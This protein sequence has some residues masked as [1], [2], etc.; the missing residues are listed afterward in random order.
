MNSPL[1]YDPVMLFRAAGTVTA[2]LSYLAPTPV[3]PC[4]YMYEPADGT[5]QDNC[6][7]VVQPMPIADARFT[8]PLL[9]VEGFELRAAPSA[10]TRFDDDEA[11]RRTYYAEAAELACAVTGARRAYVFDHQIRRREPGQKLVGF[12]R[13]GDG[14]RP[15]AVARVHNDYSEASGRARLHTVLG[16]AAAKVSRHGIVNVWRPIGGP[17]LDAP[18]AV[19]DARSVAASDLVAAEVR[20]PSRSGEIYLLTHSPRHRWYYYPAMDTDEA[21]IFKQYDSALAGVA[22]CTPHAAFE[23]PLTPPDAPPRCSIEVRILVIYQ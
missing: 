20:Y 3:R 21:L 17:V 1:R 16:A 15:A 19:C 12:G 8:A 11:I 14:S 10:L 23:H 6:E 13:R 18:L 9:D 2:G 22:R 4:S 5:P 7:Y